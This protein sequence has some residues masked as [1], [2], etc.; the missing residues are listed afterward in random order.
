VMGRDVERLEAPVVEDERGRASAGCGGGG[1]RRVPK[2]D[3]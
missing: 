3:Q 1:H 2:R